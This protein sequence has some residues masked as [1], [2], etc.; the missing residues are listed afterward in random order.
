MVYVYARY[1][2]YTYDEHFVCIFY[3]NAF[4]L[5]FKFFGNR[6]NTFFGI[7]KII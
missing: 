7:I 4:H 6:K 3:Y 5:F 2:E 1:T